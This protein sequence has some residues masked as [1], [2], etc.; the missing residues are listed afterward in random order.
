MSTPVRLGY[1]EERTLRELAQG[2]TNCPHDNTWKRTVRALA[3]KGLA[4][5]VPGM[6]EFYDVTEAGRVWMAK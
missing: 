6:P 3:K 1:V 5:P 2:A 4:R